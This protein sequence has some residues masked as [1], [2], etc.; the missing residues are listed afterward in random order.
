MI[1]KERASS[2]RNNDED[3]DP[4]NVRGDPDLELPVYPTTPVLHDLLNY[5]N[6]SLILQL[7]VRLLRNTKN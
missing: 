5:R 7:F 4:E 2:W 1:Q 6:A 3:I